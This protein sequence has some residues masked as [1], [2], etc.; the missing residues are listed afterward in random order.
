M[1]E[2]KFR[3]FIKWLNIM[4][5]VESIDFNKKRV[6]CKTEK[7]KPNPCDFYNFDDI[8]L[9][10]YTGLIDENNIKIYEG[11]IAECSFKYR[12][13]LPKFKEEVSI[14][15]TNLTLPFAREWNIPNKAYKDTV[16]SCKVLGNIYENKEL[17]K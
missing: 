14:L 13:Y 6:Y 15:S 3:A 9:M 5:E 8:I 4:L 1:K 17:L 2:I 10:Q 7:E 11:D 16:G 12:N